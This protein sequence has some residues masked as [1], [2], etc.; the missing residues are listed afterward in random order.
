[1]EIRHSNTCAHARMHSGKKYYM[2]AC[3]YVSKEEHMHAYGNFQANKEDFMHACESPSK[4]RFLLEYLCAQEIS[5]K[6]ETQNNCYADLL[7]SY[8]TG[9]K[10]RRLR[11]ERK[12]IRKGPAQASCLGVREFLSLHALGWGPPGDR[13]HEKIWKI[14]TDKRS[15]GKKRSQEIRKL[16]F[17]IDS[18]W[19]FC[20][21]DFLSLRALG[22]GPPA[23]M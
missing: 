15:A 1:M 10:K 12:E 2:H 23:C 16:L 18:V 11:F 6:S 14:S 17:S 19:K 9:D 13:L 5:N 4:A 8:C 22:W 21:F 20:L 7:I 3:H